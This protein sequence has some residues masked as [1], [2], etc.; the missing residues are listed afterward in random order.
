MYDNIRFHLDEEYPEGLPSENAATHIG[1]YWIWVAQ[2]GLANPVWQTAPESAEDFANM[3]KG[4]TSGRRFLL[5]HMDGALTPDDFTEQ[6]QKFTS[7]YNDNEED[8]YGAVLED[9]VRPL[10]TPSLGGFY[11]VPNP[12]EIYHRLKPVFQ[13][14][15]D[16]WKNNLASPV[17]EQP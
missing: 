2:T 8:G 11:H 14:A 17:G 4:R 7:Y 10:D 12:P 1:M 16:Q 5:K 15:F 6:G 13:S 9:Y 3:L